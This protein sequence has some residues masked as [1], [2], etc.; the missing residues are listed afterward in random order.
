M[1][2]NT[3]APVPTHAFQ[4]A[5]GF[6]LNPRRTCSTRVTVCVCPSVSSYS[7]TTGFEAAHERYKRLQNYAREPENLND[8]NPKTTAFE[9][10]AVK[11]IAPSYLDRSVSSLYLAEAQEVT[12]KAVQRLPH[13]H[14]I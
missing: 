7:R 6:T 14:A 10:Y 4:F 13:R 1:T 9:R 11:T 2:H 5:Q 8:E 12:T 3:H